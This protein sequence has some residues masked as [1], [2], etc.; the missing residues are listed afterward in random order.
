MFL[1]KTIKLFN[2]YTGNKEG[3]Q[4]VETN[5]ILDDFTGE[6]LT[7]NIHQNLYSISFNFNHDSEPVYYYDE[8][9]EFFEDLGVDYGGFVSNPYHVFWAT[10]QSFDNS[11]AHLYKIFENKKNLEKYSGIY[12][13]YRVARINTIK[14]LLKENKLKP[15]QLP[16]FSEN[17]A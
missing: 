2:K 10:G 5:Q 13:I 12:D 4:H 7:K 3:H 1:F 11:M 8:E 17:M 14:K 15:E 6:I 16:G 9:K